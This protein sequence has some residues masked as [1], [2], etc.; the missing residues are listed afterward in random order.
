MLALVTALI[1]VMYLV[2]FMLVGKAR[3]KSGIQ[4][5]AVT[6]D[7]EFERYFRI[8]QNTMEQLVWTLPALWLCG[9]YFP[10]AAAVLGLVFLVGRILYIIGYAKAAEKRG[11]GF[12]IGLLA[13]FLLLLGALW[14]SLTAYF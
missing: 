9:Q 11:P 6:G 5:P 4:A 7:P 10:T 14:G 8:Q 1:L 3:M 13:S 2:A 12:G